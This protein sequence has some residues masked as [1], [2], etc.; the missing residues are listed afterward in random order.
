VRWV[1]GPW[2]PVGGIVEAVGKV[3]AAGKTTLITHCCR[4]VLD[5]LPFL[6]VP[7]EKTAVVYLTEQP[8]SSFREVLRRADLLERD[9]FAV[10]YWRDTVGV[11]WPDVVAAAVAECERR[12]AGLL[13][14]DTLGRFAGLRGDAENNAGA[15]DEA[16]EPL[17]Q[18][19]AD[20]LAI[21]VLR[22]ERKGGGEIGESGRGSSAFA[23][24][25]D[26]VLAIRRGE[27][28]TRGTV[29]VIHGLSRFDETPET[30]VV[31]LTEDG[32]VALGDESQV[33]LREA[34]EAIADELS[35]EGAT[36]K[37]LQVRLP[38]VKRT[39]LQK[40]LDELTAEGLA[41]RTGARKRGEP[42]RFLSAALSAEVPAET[43]RSE[44]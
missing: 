12:G 23:G 42:Y 8:P 44:P 36:I 19:A 6:G 38:A 27:G 18:A 30:L 20:G 39:T 14:I 22:H 41:A 33:A 34:R 37:E 21:V 31:E 35:D 24:A 1:A 25:V 16:M 13:V 3:K 40:A 28:N 9:D 15:A 17:Q 5:G 11:R 2:I 10:L 29:R 43:E 32:Y 26:V 4:A 7:T